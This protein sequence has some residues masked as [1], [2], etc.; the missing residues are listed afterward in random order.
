MENEEAPTEVLEEIEAMSEVLR[1]KATYIARRVCIW[2]TCKNIDYGKNI[3]A[4]RE[5]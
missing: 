1:M 3:L 5:I 4:R 2:K